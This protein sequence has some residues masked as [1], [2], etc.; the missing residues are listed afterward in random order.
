[1]FVC[2]CF[3]LVGVTAASLSW[4][5]SVAHHVKV[6]VGEPGLG[7]PPHHVKVAGRWE[8]QRFRP[9][10]EPGDSGVEPEVGQVHV[11]CCHPLS[12]LLSVRSVELSFP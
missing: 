7:H 1:M 6:G 8:G 2:G 5:L 4:S 12:P 10:H 11:R 9:C 3:E